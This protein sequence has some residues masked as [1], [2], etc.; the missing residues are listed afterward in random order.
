ME[1]WIRRDKKKKE[2]LAQQKKNYMNKKYSFFNFF[3][4]KNLLLVRSIFEQLNH[5]YLNSNSFFFVILIVHLVMAIIHVFSNSLYT[6]KQN[7]LHDILY[8]SRL[9][10][11][12]DIL[13]FPYRHHK[14]CNRLRFAI[15]NQNN[16]F[17]QWHLDRQGICQDRN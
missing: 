1:Q 10:R 15:S 16:L 12:P 2:K 8:R 14:Q 17:Y 7:S 3:F 6:Y 5:S 9:H 4:H 11:W 13:T